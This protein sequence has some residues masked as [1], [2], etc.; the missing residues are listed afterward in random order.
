MLNDTRFAGGLNFDSA[1]W[2]LVLEQGLDRPFINFG[3]ANLTQQVKDSWPRIWPHLRGFKRQL[4]LSDSLHYTFTDFP[5][6]RDA[7]A[8]PV[9][10]KLASAG[11]LGPLSGLRVRPIMA[12]YI[13]A[14]VGFFVT[15][16]ESRLLHVPSAEHPEVRILLNMNSHSNSSTD[17]VKL[18]DAGGAST[19][20]T[21]PT[22]QDEYTVLLPEQFLTK[23]GDKVAFFAVYDGHGS[24]QVSK[25][26]KEN[27][28]RFIRES[29]ELEA[30]RYEAAIEEVIKKEESELLKGFRD[31]E[32]EFA[33]A[34]STVSLALINLTKGIMVIGNLGDS[35]IIMADYAGAKGVA[36]NVR[37]ITANHKPDDPG[38]KE[39]IE[40]A[41]G[42][43][44]FISGT[45]RLGALNMSRALGDL[46]Y[47]EPLVNA[48]TGPVNESMERAGFTSSHEQKSPLSS[49]PYLSRVNLKDG[50]QHVI[51]L[52][53]D[54]VT[55][56]LKDNIIV[57]GILT[58][59]RSGLNA[60]ESS[61]YLIDE[62][63]DVSGSD[64]ATCIAIFIDDAS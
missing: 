27:I 34:G 2:G 10:V 40:E 22:Q 16:E 14:A 25:H 51:L 5:L 47:K 24:N 52:T 7:A 62:A 63:V 3:E 37:R 44:N 13:V 42:L 46:Q 6:V 8:W 49:E 35:H 59:Y 57:H 38:E 64:N 4:Q 20:G 30:G 28:R 39:R 15:G 23:S 11:L 17:A 43:V 58:C 33:T 50:S 1:L 61:K 21:R 36:T 32:E 9:K 41:G 60:T 54:G 19:I 26:A 12:D 48:G 56:A 31:G 53:T 18:Q 29:P 45:A 55:N